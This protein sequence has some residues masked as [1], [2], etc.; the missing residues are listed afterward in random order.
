MLL[1]G[2]AR[3]IE[4]S[5]PISCQRG[6]FVGKWSR[7]GGNSST[8]KSRGRKHRSRVMTSPKK[9]EV[10]EKSEGKEKLRGTR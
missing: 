6:S 1:C 3:R 10:C 4:K 9:S 2:D 5:D 8:K 7:E